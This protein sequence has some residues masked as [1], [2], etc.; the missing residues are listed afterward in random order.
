MKLYWRKEEMLEFDLYCYIKHKWIPDLIKVDYRYEH[1]D[2]YSVNYQSI[3]EL[4]C[5]EKHYRN[6]ILQ[7]NKYDSLVSLAGKMNYRA[8][9]VTRTVRGIYCWE[10][11]MELEW[12]KQMLPLNTEFGCKTKIPKTVAYLDTHLAKI[13]S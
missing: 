12:E 7:K 11:P 4:K 10:F 3:F 13:L 6:L 5:R 8:L 9:Y 2:A 1:Y